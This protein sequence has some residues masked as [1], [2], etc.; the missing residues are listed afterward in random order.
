LIYFE[1]RQKRLKSDV[2]NALRV[3]IVNNW[4]DVLD[5]SN[6]YFN[7][8]ENIKSS[9]KFINWKSNEYSRDT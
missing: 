4:Y 8:Y 3:Q 2:P 5:N 9:Y 6:D 7:Y 1:K